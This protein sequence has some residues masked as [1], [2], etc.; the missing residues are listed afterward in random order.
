MGIRTVEIPYCDICISED[1]VRVFLLNFWG[2][3]GDHATVI[4]RKVHLCV[5]CQEKVLKFIAEK[6]VGAFQFSD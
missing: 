6:S 2:H 3:D 5:E 4:C 1:G